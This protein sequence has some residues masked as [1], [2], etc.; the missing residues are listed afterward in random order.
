M[1][2]EERNL[3][4]AWKLGIINTFQYLEL[5]RKLSVL[6]VITIALSACAK[7]NEISGVEP[8]GFLRGSCTLGERATKFQLYDEEG[9]AT[10]SCW[11][12]TDDPGQCYVCERIGG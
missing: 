10:H 11:E 4:A 5:F 3:V 2:L 8:T 6:A 7:P 12:P 1:T 9:K